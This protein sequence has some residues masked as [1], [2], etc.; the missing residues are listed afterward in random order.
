MRI[1]L[2]LALFVIP[3]LALAL[4]LPPLNA[5]PL[6]TQAVET[7]TL[8]ID[9]KESSLTYHAIHKLHTVHARS[10]AVDGRAR[11]LPNGAQVMIRVPSDSFDSQNTNRDAHIKESIEAEKFPLIELRALVDG[12]VLPTTFPTTIDKTVKAQLI[13]H[14][15]TKTLDLPVKIVVESATKI[16]ATASFAVSLEAFK[17]ERPQLMFVKVNDQVKIDAVLVFGK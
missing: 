12:F 11:L 2:L 5:A 1:L 3:R 16:R 15:V 13:F 6:P 8:A 17:V 14:G 4:G 9:K 7:P 10:T